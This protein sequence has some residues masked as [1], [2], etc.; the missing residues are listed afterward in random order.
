MKPFINL[1]PQ[2]EAVTAWR[3]MPRACANLETKSRYRNLRL[4]ASGVTRR[5]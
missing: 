3:F 4:H 2:P 5:S 1:T